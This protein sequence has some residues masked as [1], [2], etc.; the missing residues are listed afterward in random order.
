[1]SKQAI[2]LRAESTG[3][4]VFLMDPD[5]VSA[6]IEVDQV[7]VDGIRVGRNFVEGPIVSV[8]GFP[9]EVAETLPQ[10][11]LQAVGVGN[12]LG[13]AARFRKGVRRYV[14]TPEGVEPFRQ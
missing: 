3:N 7:I 10:S 12:H 8:H 13:I 2:S 4:K 11:L 5:N 14:V 1:M 9:Q 6:R